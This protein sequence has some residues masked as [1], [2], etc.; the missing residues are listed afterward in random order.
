MTEPVLYLTDCTDTNAVARLTIRVS[1]LLDSHVRVLPL[2]DSRPDLMA[3]LTLVDVIASTHLTGGK[4]SVCTV[5]INIAPRYDDSPNGLP[6]CYFHVQ[7]TLVVT[8]A[9]PEVL[10]F[11]RKFLGI[12][13]VH[14][15]DISEVMNAATAWAPF[16]DE[17][18][19]TIVGSQFRS[20]WYL[21][22]LARWVKEGRPIPAT[23]YLAPET[24]DEG[25]VAVV[26]NFGNC[27]TTSLPSGVGFS[28][29]GRIKVSTPLG[30]REV[31]CYERLT[32]V[33]PAEVGIVIGSSGNGLL[34]LVIN[35]GSA[36]GELGVAAGDAVFNS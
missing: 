15:T 18:V 5:L 13:E 20:L 6:F 11:A 17:Q 32:D 14:V 34:E 22:L 24:P 16:T 26:D 35:G 10:A 12:T 4:P 36:A 29:G 1:A 7:G 28:V 25:V 8:T 31:T 30:L 19:R 2:D 21:P 23:P 3:G 33:P 9:N 27:K